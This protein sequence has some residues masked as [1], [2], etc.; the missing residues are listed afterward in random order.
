MDVHT[1]VRE[2]VFDIYIKKKHS[3]FSDG[4]I[5]YSI[6]QGDKRSYDIQFFDETYDGYNENGTLKGKKNILY[7]ENKLINLSIL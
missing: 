7:K 1:K 2:N 6:P 3:E 4:P 5:S